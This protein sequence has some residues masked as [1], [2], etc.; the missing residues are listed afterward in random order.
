MAGE[1]TIGALCNT[2]YEVEE[3]AGK[4][5]DEDGSNTEHRSHGKEAVYHK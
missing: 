5:R 4:Y 3:E 2:E 1:A